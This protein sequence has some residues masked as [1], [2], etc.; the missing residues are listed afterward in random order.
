MT[1]PTKCLGFFGW[2]R[3]HKWFKFSLDF[4]IESD[5]CLR[6]GMPKG[7]WR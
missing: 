6:C 2:L 5:Y 1:N 3:G 4:Y 7:G